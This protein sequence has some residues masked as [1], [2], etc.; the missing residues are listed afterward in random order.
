MPAPV[1]GRLVVADESALQFIYKTT[2]M[3]SIAY[4]QFIDIEYG[5]KS[6]R[7]AG[8]LGCQHSAA[9]IDRFAFPNVEEAITLRHDWIQG[10]SR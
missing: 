5:Q 3:V 7:R 10:R 6:G 2:P 8:A 4:A 1:D 9:R